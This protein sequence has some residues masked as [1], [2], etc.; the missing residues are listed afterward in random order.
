M[1]Y[2][3]TKINLQVRESISLFFFVKIK[4]YWLSISNPKSQNSCGYLHELINMFF[5]CWFHE[6][7]FLNWLFTRTVEFSCKSYMFIFINPGE[8]WV[9]VW[10]LEKQSLKTFRSVYSTNVLT[11]PDTLKQH[12]ND[13][14]IA[15]SMNTN[16]Y[17]R[18]IPMTTFQI[19][20]LILSDFFTYYLY[21][22]TEY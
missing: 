12:H 20:D 21:M 19:F 4:T 13:E 18:T 8:F 9:Y 22:H 17:S 10:S 11:F 3:T 15:E 7:I 2:T 14:Q 6:W 16:R 5:V 1:Y